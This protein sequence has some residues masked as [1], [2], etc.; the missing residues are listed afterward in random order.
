MHDRNKYYVLLRA[1]HAIHV[2]F[3]AGSESLNARQE[4]IKNSVFLLKSF[5]LI[6]SF[7][8][9][10]TLFFN[11]YEI[12]CKQSFYI[13]LFIVYMLKYLINFRYFFLKSL[14]LVLLLLTS[15]L[16]YF[17][18]CLSIFFILYD[19]GARIFDLFLSIFNFQQ[20]FKN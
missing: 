1:L 10:L 4:Q 2:N 7:L 9:P 6:L 15:F 16:Y 11:P 17:F 5:V 20:L 18:I 14:T 3:F 8:N 12:T 19:L 13:F